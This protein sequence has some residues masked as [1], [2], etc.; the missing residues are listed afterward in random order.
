RPVGGPDGRG[1]AD[2]R[3]PEATEGGGP[4]GRP[5]AVAGATPPRAGEGQGRRRQG[6]GGVGHHG[7]RRRV[8]GGPGE[9]AVTKRFTTEGTEGTEKTRQREI[10]F[11]R[12]KGR[13]R[14]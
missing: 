9:G 1:A 8:P 2:R 12:Q 3:R 7:D 14:W 4:A 13:V 6:R 11:S 5:P 10:Q